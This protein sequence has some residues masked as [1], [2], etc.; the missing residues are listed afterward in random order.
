MIKIVQEQAATTS[1][2][3]T[4]KVQHPHKKV[5]QFAPNTTPTGQQQPIIP[6]NL[7]GSVHA[8]DNVVDHAVHSVPVDNNLANKTQPSVPS[9]PA[10]SIQA[11]NVP[12]NATQNNTTVPRTSAAVL[13]HAYIPHNPSLNG[14]SVSHPQ[15][16][17]RTYDVS[18]DIPVTLQ[19]GRIYCSL[20]FAPCQELLP[21]KFHNRQQ[22]HILPHYSLSIHQHI[23]AYN[24]CAV[25]FFWQP[26]CFLQV[27][28]IQAL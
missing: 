26:K 16:S 13:P 2:L 23:I 15:N 14:K 10:N 12:S 9:I 6:V 18:A 3:K 21:F 20:L 25:I 24:K 1:L 7:Q 17:N 8:Q 4:Q 11:A 22:F 28:K 19:H 5:Q 27:H